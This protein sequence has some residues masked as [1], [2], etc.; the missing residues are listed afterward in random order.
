MNRGFNVGSLGLYLGF[1]KGS[2]KGYYKGA[3]RVLGGFDV[4]TSPGCQPPV[5]NRLLRRQRL[6]LAGYPGMEHSIILATDTAASKAK[7]KCNKNA[8]PHSC[9]RSVGRLPGTRANT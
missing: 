2:F 3:I 1:Y 5:P 8:S 9:A 7:G 6:R 4:G